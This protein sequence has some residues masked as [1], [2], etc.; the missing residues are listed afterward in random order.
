LISEF[1]ILHTIPTQQRMATSTVQYTMWSKL[2]YR[3]FVTGPNILE[4]LLLC[5]W[6]FLAMVIKN[7]WKQS[8]CLC[9]GAV[10]NY[11]G[12]VIY[13]GSSF[14]WDCLYAWA[15]LGY[16]VGLISLMLVSA[17]FEW[18]RGDGGDQ[19]FERA[20]MRIFVEDVPEDFEGA[21]GLYTWAAMPV[22]A[23]SWI[24]AQWHFSTHI[25]IECTSLCENI[26]ACCNTVSYGRDLPSIFG[27]AVGNFIGVF[28][29]LSMIATLATRHGI[30]EHEN[31]HR[32]LNTW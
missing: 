21:S 2:L 23:A 15:I 14:G 1:Y 4:T 8:I 28:K 16:A 25:T 3:L 10:V 20:F 12:I 27:I 5:P 31:L 9:I 22:A 18:S 30:K 13:L 24:A 11:G 29:G 19:E 26:T 17:F 6:S 7:G 32:R